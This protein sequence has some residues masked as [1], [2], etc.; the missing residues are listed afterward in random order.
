LKCLEPESEYVS[1]PAR[2]YNAKDNSQ[3]KE[4]KMKTLIVYGT[5]Y[6][7][8]TGT[9]EEIAKTLREEGFNVRVV[10][11]KEEKVDDIS[12]YELIIVGSGMK[13][14]RWTKEPEN[15]LKKFR[16]ELAKKRVAIF[17]SS[18]VQAIYEYEGNT[19]AMGRARRKYLEEKAEKYSL[20][21]IAMAIFGG[22]FPYDKMGW[23]ERKTVG[24]LWRKFEDAGFEKKNGVYDTRNWDTIRNWTKE[25]TKKVSA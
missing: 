25:L 7:A 6:G 23:M 16:K 8:T 15:F 10:N 13:I 5:R 12:G 14:D 2:K 4:W 20:T 19:E 1:E 11:A 17:V 3:E 24:Q 21:P 22:V 9:S 18:S